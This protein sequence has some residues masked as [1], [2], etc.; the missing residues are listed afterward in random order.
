M[1]S[2]FA[3]QG[4][5]PTKASHFPGHHPTIPGREG[6]LYA[7]E[8]DGDI[9]VIVGFAT[10][11]MSWIDTIQSQTE[12]LGR[13][14]VRGVL[15][16]PHAEA[17]ANEQTLLAQCREAAGLPPSHAVALLP[18]D[19]RHVGKLMLRLPQTRATHEARKTDLSAQDA[20]LR[21]FLSTEEPS[22]QH[23]PR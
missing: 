11:P 13:Q 15:T 10:G 22:A 8:F 18:L 1:L 20:A 12:R 6:H 4:N 21:E 14:P 23:P 7:V 17:E 9:G 2:F 3:F 16:G 5:Q 19:L